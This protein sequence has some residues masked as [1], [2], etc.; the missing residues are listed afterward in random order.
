M[1]G[2][3][4]GTSGTNSIPGPQ[5]EKGGETER[6]RGRDRELRKK[7]RGREGRQREREK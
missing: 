6:Q 1:E 5:R 4:R 3:Y 7:E 2:E